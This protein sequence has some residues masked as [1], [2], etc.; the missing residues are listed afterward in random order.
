MAE[1]ETE[2]PSKEEVSEASE[3]E[4]STE[5]GDLSLKQKL[6]AKPMLIKIGI[7]LVVV[8]LS[9]GGAFYFM[10]GDELPEDEIVADAVN[11]ADSSETDDSEESDEEAAEIELDDI[12]EADAE[13]ADIESDEL[14]EEDGT[15]VLD[16]E[17]IE[18]PSIDEEGSSVTE[19]AASIDASKEE[20]EDKKSTEVELS[21]I[22]KKAT[23]L[24][25]ENARLKEQIS[26][27]EALNNLEDKDPALKLRANQY[28]INRHTKE[29]SDYPLRREIKREP[30]PEPKWGEFNTIPK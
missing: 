14:S 2:E 5:E 22:F 27:L 17:G 26:E 1:N 21:K 16:E 9:A 23:E 24:Q 6:L 13:T 30:P 4:T 10:S 28:I 3:D 29:E 8:L 25:E 20:G 12:G 15:E 7:G 11:E 18:L 19:E